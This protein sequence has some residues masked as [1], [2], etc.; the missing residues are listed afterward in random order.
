MGIDRQP[1]AALE[2]RRLSLRPSPTP[3]S[4]GQWRTQ[5]KKLL[6]TA[7]ALFVL[8]APA[9][10]DQ[11]PGIYFGQW[12]GEHHPNVD[13][14]EEKTYEKARTCE[15][16]TSFEIKPNGFDYGDG[17]CRFASVRKTGRSM[18]RWTKPIAGNW[19][20]GDW[21]PEVKLV[22]KC[23]GFTSALRLN[24]NKGDVLTITG[25]AD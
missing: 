6:M 11:L 7:A 14:G 20:N 23:H 12:C 18:P 5:M 4:T 24:W 16:G 8:V 9:H 22:L 19:P 15:K 2:E 25:M 10:A 3:M 13:A 21:V 1:R 17:T